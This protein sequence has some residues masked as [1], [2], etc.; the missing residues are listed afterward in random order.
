MI[1]TVRDAA[2]PPTTNPER[3]SE[4]A[5]GEV[6]HKD[7]AASLW[8]ENADES[9][10]P[11]EANKPNLPASPDQHASRRRRSLLESAM[12]ISGFIQQSTLLARSRCSSG[13]RQ[14][15]T[16]L[17][18]CPEVWLPNGIIQGNAAQFS[19]EETVSHVRKSHSTMRHGFASRGIQYVPGVF[20]DPAGCAGPGEQFS[21]RTER[22][23]TCG[24]AFGDSSPGQ[25]AA[26][27]RITVVPGSEPLAVGISRLVVTTRDIHFSA[28]SYVV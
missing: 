24:A 6:P 18:P 23:G 5:T 20:S 11:V 16:T 4:W 28:G 19:C 2:R 27:I 25:L 22:S 14:F 7:A 8:C 10:I 12:E 13:R 17:V 9:W 3:A 21:A 1:L 26:R 15:H